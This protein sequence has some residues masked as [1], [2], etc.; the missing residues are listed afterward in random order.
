MNRAKRCLRGRTDR[1][2]WSVGCRPCER[3]QNWDE[4]ALCLGHRMINGATREERT[5]TGQSG[6]TEAHELANS[7]WP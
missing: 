3:R 1:N 7:E 5:Q 6:G 2:W 4:C